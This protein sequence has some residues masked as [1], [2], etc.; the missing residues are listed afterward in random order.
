[1]EKT[2][3]KGAVGA[4]LDIYEQTLSEFK[5]TIQDIPNHTLP[6]VVD[7][8]TTNEDCK[9]IQGILSH[10]VSAGYGYATSIANF[11]GQTIEQPN[12]T[13]HPTIQE[14]LTD[15]THVFTFTENVFLNIPDMELE[16][17]DNTLKIKIGSGQVY[18]IE[19]LT[20]HAIVHV[21]R[22]KRQ[23]EK[24]KYQNSTKNIR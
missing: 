19:Q 24:I 6:F 8:H 16:Q 13:I 15:L 14:Y 21:L 3:R 23:I 20:E 22:H 10:V 1:M 17:N 11:K 18:D 2:N 7:P 4:L 12:K 9:S 5:K